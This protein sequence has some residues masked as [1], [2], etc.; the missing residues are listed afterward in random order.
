[1]DS[2][3]A[4]RNSAPSQEIAEE[5]MYQSNSFSRFSMAALL[6]AGLLLGGRRWLCPDEAGDD[7]GRAD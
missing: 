6:M 5:R 1:M 4:W 3:F 2:M 7:A